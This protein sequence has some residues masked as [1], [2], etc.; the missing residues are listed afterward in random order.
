MGSRPKGRSFYFKRALNL[1]ADGSPKCDRYAEKPTFASTRKRQA[2]QRGSGLP[3]GAAGFL[4]GKRSA[5]LYFSGEDRKE[6]LEGI[7]RIAVSADYRIHP[8]EIV[9]HEYRRKD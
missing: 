7:V 3:K 6:G 9:H 1:N 2:A 5:R 8:V 4:K